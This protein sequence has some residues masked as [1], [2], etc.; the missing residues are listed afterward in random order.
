MVSTSLAVFGIVYPAV[1]ADGY[2]GADGVLPRVTPDTVTQMIGHLDVLGQ[3][4]AAMPGEFP[5]M[6]FDG[7][8]AVI[9]WQEHSLADDRLLEIHRCYPDQDGLYAIGAHQWTWKT[10]S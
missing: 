5:N 3:H 1:I 7:D 4:A 10:V 6:R 2:E 9:S 8:V